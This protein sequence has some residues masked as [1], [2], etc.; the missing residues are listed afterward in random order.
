LSF[1]AGK[2]SLRRVLAR[3]DGNSATIDLRVYVARKGLV[4]ATLTDAI[5]SGAEVY[6]DS[7]VAAAAD[8]DPEVNITGDP[9]QCDVR[10]DESMYVYCLTGDAAVN[11]TV[12]L[13]L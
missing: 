12:R 8:P 13:Y 6:A 1:Q 10:A 9:T 5:R 3:F 11:G 4:L 7:S 2:Y